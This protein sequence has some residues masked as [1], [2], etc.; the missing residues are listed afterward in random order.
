MDRVVATAVGRSN[1]VATS[2]AP[3]PVNV[4]SVTVFTDVATVVAEPFVG[5][6]P[7]LHENV[8]FSL[9]TVADHDGN[10]PTAVILLTDVVLRVTAVPDTEP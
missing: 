1:D 5:S 9:V 2:L 6:V 4:G 10:V 7:A 8:K 3:V